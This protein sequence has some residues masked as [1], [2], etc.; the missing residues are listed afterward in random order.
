M[1][2][3]LRILL[4]TLLLSW[5]SSILSMEQ[6]ASIEPFQG[7]RDATIDLSLEPTVRFNDQLNDTDTYYDSS[8]IR[9]YSRDMEEEIRI[10]QTKIMCSTEYFHPRYLSML[11]L[12]PTDNL[13]PHT[14]DQ[15]VARVFV[16][17][18]AD[19]NLVLGAIL[20]NREI[21]PR[22]SLRS[23]V[24]FALNHGAAWNSADNDLVSNIIDDYLMSFVLIE[25]G[26]DLSVLALQEKW[27]QFN[28]NEPGI[29]ITRRQIK[30]QIQELFLLAVGQAKNGVVLKILELFGHAITNDLMQEA[31]TAAAYTG[32][33]DLLSFFNTYNEARMVIEPSWGQT[34]SYALCRAIIRAVM[35][36]DPWA[37]NFILNPDNGF[38]SFRLDQAIEYIMHLQYIKNTPREIVKKYRKILSLPKFKEVLALQESEADESLLSRV[39]PESRAQAR[40]E[41]V[42]AQVQDAQQ[43]KKPKPTIRKLIRSLSRKKSKKNKGI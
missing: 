9:Y 39:L 10:N 18:G 13:T 2:N 28:G 4:T 16:D 14:F 38:A 12:G 42:Q 29:T 8:P 21:L 43:P 37:L 33:T 19:L 34:L 24:I 26:E 11:M 17:Y 15:S 30:R 25:R 40:Q 5:A 41:S 35:F 31:Y 32:N 7:Q 27:K 6:E 23:A 20:Q 36:D 1:K 3:T 22:N